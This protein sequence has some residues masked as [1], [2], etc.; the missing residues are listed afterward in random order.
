MAVD[1]FILVVPLFADRRPSDGMEC[2]PASLNIYPLPL[3][4]TDLVSIQLPLI[5]QLIIDNHDD[6]GK[7]EE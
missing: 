5:I 3:S 4:T 6:H 7:K 1:Q 2:H